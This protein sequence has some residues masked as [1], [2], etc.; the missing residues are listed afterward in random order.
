MISFSEY[1]PEVINA[2]KGLSPEAI[3]KKYEEAS[4]IIKSTY[5]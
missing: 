2:G 3:K 1:P 5:W 4:M